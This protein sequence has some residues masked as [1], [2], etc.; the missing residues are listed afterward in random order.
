MNK[1]F[2]GWLFT[3]FGGAGTVVLLYTSTFGDGWDWL[4]DMS[5]LP[6]YLLIGP[7]ALI[8][9]LVALGD[10]YGKSGEQ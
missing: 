6:K 4:T 3:I 1:K 9:G 10:A 5:R 8:A 7:L 2:G